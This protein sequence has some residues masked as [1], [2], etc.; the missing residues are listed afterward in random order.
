MLSQNL[1]NLM[2]DSALQ[3]IGNFNIFKTMNSGQYGENDLRQKY[4]SSALVNKKEI[5][6]NGS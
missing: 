2:D 4:A 1:S 3:D 5:S 6:K